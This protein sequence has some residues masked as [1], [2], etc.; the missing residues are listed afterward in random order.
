MTISVPI[1]RAIGELAEPLW[2][3]VVVG[4]GPAGALA[5]RQLALAGARVMLLDR[6]RFPR[7]KVCGCCIG[8]AALGVLD[9]VGLGR[10]V[11]CLGARS[12]GRV[13]VRTGRSRVDLPL[14]G[15]AAVAR[16]ELDNA[17]AGAA[18]EAGAVF[19][20]GVSGV[21]GPAGRD[22][23]L[24]TLRRGAEQASV[25]ARVV[26][27][28]DGLSGR[29]T[30]QETGMAFEV[31][32]GSRMGA[33]AILR[34]AD[35]QWSD[36]AVTM[37]CAADGYVGVV[38]LSSEHVA[39][40]AALDPGTVR[41]LGGPGPAVRAILDGAGL[42]CPR[43]IDQAP[44]RGTPA[45]TRRRRRIAAP[46]LLLVGDA[47]GYVEPF[48]GEGIGWALAGGVAVAPHALRAMRE[49]EA[50]RAWEVEHT[51]LLARRQRLCRIV[52]AGLRRGWARRAAVRVHGVV[53]SLGR[54]LAGRVAAG[55]SLGP[56]AS[57]SVR[58]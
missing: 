26:I 19:A 40:A 7:P 38:R 35:P 44:W 58:A 46:R 12:L 55:L 37:A 45:L 16:A 42:P 22:A 39:V 48:T 32:S 28:A 18:V 21:L 50:P 14:A 2:D 5:A 4:A 30:E 1:G 52:A 3:A 53:P 51:R 27:A 9:T 11:G 8:A 54:S 41:S 43:A 10:I 24:V 6:A 15:G 31:G 47:A 29:L 17:L 36:G 23:R 33:G 34:D 13:E 57:T 20:D 25:R 49:P 56:V